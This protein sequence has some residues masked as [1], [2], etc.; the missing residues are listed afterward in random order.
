M[1][2]LS[3]KLILLTLTLTQQVSVISPAGMDAALSEIYWQK[4]PFGSLN[5]NIHYRAAAAL[6]Y[7]R[8]IV[9]LTDPS[10]PITL[11]RI[12]STNLVLTQY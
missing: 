5:K 7:L 2:Q 8:K 3:T 12:L 11:G 1:Y 6:V 9:A 10:V 4:V